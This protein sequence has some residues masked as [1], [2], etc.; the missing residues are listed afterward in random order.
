MPTL[1][2]KKMYCQKLK[3]NK[4]RLDQELIKKYKSPLKNLSFLRVTSQI[5]N[6]MQLNKIPNWILGFFNK[7]GPNT[8]G[9]SNKSDQRI[10]N[11]E[12]LNKPQ[13]FQVLKIICKY[14]KK[15][16]KLFSFIL[17]HKQLKAAINICMFHL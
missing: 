3:Q 16:K 9:K 10:Y 6:Q 7:T 4:S 5:K 14:S 8:G 13:E 1:F 12:L 15:N 17:R 2:D 11:K